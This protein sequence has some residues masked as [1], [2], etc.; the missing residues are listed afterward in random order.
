MDAPLLDIRE[1]KVHFLTGRGH[2]QAV[3]GVSLRIERGE[4]LAV[5]GETGSGKSVTA[6]SLLR[7]VGAGGISDSAQ[8]DGAYLA[9]ARRG[10]PIRFA[11]PFPA[12]NSLHPGPADFDDFPGTDDL[13]ESCLTVGDQIAEVIIR[14]QGL[15]RREAL[16]DRGRN[17][18]T[19]SNS[20]GEVT[21]ES[22]PISFRGEC[23]SGYDCDG[24]CLPARAADC[25]R[26][27]DCARC[28]HPGPDP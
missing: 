23:D 13:A 19:G 18:G 28:D 26:T 5:V 11:V 20:G 3:D 16:Q 9:S 2:H 1:L 17:D 21:T 27:D 6:L 10:Y 14:H 12:G 4:T 25:R 22:L 24:P 8:M 15:T 7:L